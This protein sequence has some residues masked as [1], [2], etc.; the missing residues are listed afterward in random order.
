MRIIYI[1]LYIYIQHVSCRFLQVAVNHI[2]ENGTKTVNHDGKQE[3]DVEVRILFCLSD[4]R[5]RECI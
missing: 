1:C 2:T 5:G 3:F 4:K